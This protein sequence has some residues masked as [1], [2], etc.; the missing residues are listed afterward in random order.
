[1]VVVVGGGI[2]KK[3]WRA[4]LV[5]EALQKVIMHYR[6]KGKILWKYNRNRRP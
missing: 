2:I 3:L 1:M 5:T 6:S 4:K